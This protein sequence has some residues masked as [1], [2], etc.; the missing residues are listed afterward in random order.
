[1]FQSL[2]HE[3]NA[4]SNIE[5]FHYLVSYLSGPALTVVK[6]VPL[7]A[8]NYAI[9]WNDLQ[10]RYENQRLLVTAHV[11]KLFTFAP[12]QSESAASLSLFVNT[13]HE[14]VAAIEALGVTD[15]AGFLLF[16][17]GSRVIDP[18]TRRMFKASTKIPNLEI[19]LEIVA[20]RCKILENVGSAHLAILLAK[21]N[22]ALFA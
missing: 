18:A 15:L 11:E 10:E 19:L 22:Y 8:D 13:F 1:M 4:Y 7:T 21:I 2:V 3:N 9:A 14:N 20:Q 17:I 12:L 16:Y 6:M 5:R